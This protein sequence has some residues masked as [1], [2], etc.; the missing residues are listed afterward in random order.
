MRFLHDHTF[1]GV[2]RD[3][4]LLA[5]L[6]L[7]LIAGCG[8]GGGNGNSG[9]G[10]TTTGTNTAGTNTGN[11]HS[12]TV[13]ATTA[14]GLTASLTE[15]SSTVAVNGSLT[16]TM[17]LTNNTSAAIPVHATSTP[18]IPSAGVVVTGPTG[19]ITFQ[20]LP[21]APPLANGLLNSGQSISLT[22]VATG[23]T[24]AGTYSAKATFGDDTTAPATVGPLTVTAQ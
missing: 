16:Y 18:S 20:A 15:N 9:T 1:R 11:Q 6:T 22:Q 13:S 23:F 17:T 8:G 4:G 3:C 12:Q 5:L 19:T 7:P 2:C 14:T 21:G 10:T 24:S